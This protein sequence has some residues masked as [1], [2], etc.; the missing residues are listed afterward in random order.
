MGE[1]T[2]Y[3][4]SKE[5]DEERKKGILERRELQNDDHE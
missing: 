2:A 4:Y 3:F 5:N 1:I